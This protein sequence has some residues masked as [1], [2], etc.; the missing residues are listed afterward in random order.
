MTVDKVIPTVDSP[1]DAK[2]V[3]ATRFQRM[4]R[5]CVRERIDAGAQL[6][7]AAGH[8]HGK[9]PPPLTATGVPPVSEHN[10]TRRQS[11]SP[12]CGAS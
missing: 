9:T 5:T 2:T 11:A 7:T 4:I 1:V 8:L 3:A 12:D 10:R 6:V